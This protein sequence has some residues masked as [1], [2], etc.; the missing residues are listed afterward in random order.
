MKKSMVMETPKTMENQYDN[1]EDLGNGQGEEDV[2]DL[3]AT[4]IQREMIMM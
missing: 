1:G 2:I 4:V 3:L